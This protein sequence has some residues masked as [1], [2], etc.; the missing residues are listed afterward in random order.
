MIPS[1]ANVNTQRTNLYPNSQGA[2]VSVPVDAPAKEEGDSVHFTSKQEDKTF[3]EKNWGKL[4][5]GAGAITA[6]VFL[7]KGK[8]WGKETFVQAQK[9]LSE[10]FRKD[11]PKEEAE[12][13]LKRY[14]ELFK[15]QD[16]EEFIKQIY[17]QAKKDYGYEHLDLNY[18]LSKGKVIDGAKKAAGGFHPLGLDVNRNSLN[19]YAFDFAQDHSKESLFGIIMH[20]LRHCK[21]H[22]IA[23]RTDKEKFMQVLLNA[24]TQSVGVRDAY[25]KGIEK[26][27]S[28]VWDKLPKIQPGTKE[29][30]QGMKYI[31]NIGLYKNGDESGYLSQILETDA[32]DTET[33][34]KK[35]YKFINLNSN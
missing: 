29:Y 12:A 34:A 25:K 21:Q 8:L 10:I 35:I 1:I 13:M 18:I 28:P 2:G 7:T 23:Y 17:N 24:R 16:K 4:L 31:D 6:G 32:R 30:E 9:N 5:L 20:E 22:E 14:K 11:I 33:K 19:N 15:I 27:Y 26:I 3:V